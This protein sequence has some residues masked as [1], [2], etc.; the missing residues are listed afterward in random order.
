M[1]WLY[2]VTLLLSLS[3]KKQAQDHIAQLLIAASS[4]LE[5]NTAPPKS[6]NV[7]APDTDVTTG[8][9][10]EVARLAILSTIAKSKQNLE[11]S[12]YAPKNYNKSSAN[13]ATPTRNAPAKSSFSNRFSPLGVDQPEMSPSTRSQDKVIAK[14]LREQTLDGACRPHQ[15]VKQSFTDN[16][17]SRREI[18]SIINQPLFQHGEWQT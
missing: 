17:Y 6:A 11:D 12:K 7:P 3:N 4:A 2:T 10:L 8:D 18:S 16:P 14:F 1:A 13:P 9:P 5:T 15:S